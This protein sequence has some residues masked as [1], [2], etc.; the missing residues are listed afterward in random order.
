MLIILL[1][2]AEN[3]CLTFRSVIMK[4]IN[5]CVCHKS[6]QF[7]SLPALLEIELHLAD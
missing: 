3:K 2:R 6:R 1:I 7:C 5:L 4:I